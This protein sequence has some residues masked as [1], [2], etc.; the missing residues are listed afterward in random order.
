MDPPYDNGKTGC[1]E[2]D[3]DDLLGAIELASA[4]NDSA[5]EAVD[6]YNEAMEMVIFSL[7]HRRAIL[8]RNRKM[9]GM[10]NIILK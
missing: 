6:E 8:A 5:I 10:V 2:E 4:W 3:D 9:A 7:E 1:T